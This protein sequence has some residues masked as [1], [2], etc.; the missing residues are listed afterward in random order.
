MSIKENKNNI[1]EKK[2]K[3]GVIRNH[4]NKTKLD[5]KKMNQLKTRKKQSNER[6]K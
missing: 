6:T 4:E 2:L 5:K 3:N 1:S